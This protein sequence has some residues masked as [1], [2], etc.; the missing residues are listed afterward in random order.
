MADTIELTTAEETILNAIRTAL[1]AVASVDG[2]LSGAPTATTPAA[3]SSGDQI[4]TAA[5]V[6]TLLSSLKLTTSKLVANQAERLLLSVDAAEG[7]AVI[8]ADTGKS[9]MLKSA[10]LVG[11]SGAWDATDWLQLGDRDITWTDVNKSGAQPSDIGA[12]ATNPADIPGA[13]AVTNIVRM[14]QAAYNAL[15]TPDPNVT[16]IIIP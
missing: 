9:W 14:T 11:S 13:A 2:H 1:G 4:A 5:F 8:D 6:K 12:V 16:Y 7:F 10:G 3:E 15:G